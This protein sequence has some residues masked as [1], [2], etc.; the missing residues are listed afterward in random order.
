MLAAAGM[1]VRTVGAIIN[2]QQKQNRNGDYQ[3][4]DGDTEII[5]G[6]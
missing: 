6:E 1:S 3:L 2:R 4:P 5:T